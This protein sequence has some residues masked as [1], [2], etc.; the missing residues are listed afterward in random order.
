[1]QFVKEKS[2]YIDQETKYLLDYIRQWE[3]RNTG[4]EMVFITLPK[5]DQDERKRV[6]EAAVK[7]LSKGK[8][9][10]VE[11]DENRERKGAGSSVTPKEEI[12]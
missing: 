10:V 7:I 12:L 9:T 2:S 11:N 8:F 5:Y 6:L 3:K 1:M 4:E